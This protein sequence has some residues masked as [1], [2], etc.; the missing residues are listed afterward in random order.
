MLTP[1]Q[2]SALRHFPALPSILLSFS[3]LSCSPSDLQHRDEPPRPEMVNPRVL[4]DLTFGDLPRFGLLPPGETDHLRGKNVILLAMAV[5]PMGRGDWVAANALLGIELL[6]ADSLV[7]HAYRSLF[8]SL[9]S[10]QCRI[11][12]AILFEE[13]LFTDYDGT[14]KGAHISPTTD[15]NSL[16]FRRESSIISAASNLNSRFIYND[17]GNFSREY[18][19]QPQREMNIGLVKTFKAGM[20]VF[21]ELKARGV[22]DETLGDLLGMLYA[23]LVFDKSHQSLYSETALPHP[24]QLYSDALADTVEYFKTADPESS[25]NDPFLSKLCLSMGSRWLNGKYDS[26]LF[27]TDSKER[28]AVLLIVSDDLNAIQLSG[29]G[30]GGVAQLPKH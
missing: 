3:L 10:D 23:S 18:S 15:R 13:P 25:R 11:H 8:R 30:P 2:P 9:L 22:V 17:Y 28:D 1:Q 12:S 29:E 26:L 24:L 27:P 14:G 16:I 4:A 7:K 20:S 5:G 19:P 6:D 21:L